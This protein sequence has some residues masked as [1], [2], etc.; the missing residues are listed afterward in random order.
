MPIRSTGACDD[1]TAA[2]IGGIAAAGVVEG[3]VEVARVVVVVAGGGIVGGVVL[4]AGVAVEQHRHAARV[5]AGEV[6]VGG[7]EIDGAVTA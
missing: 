7:G 4:V 1:G 6:A 3:A 2:G 5:G